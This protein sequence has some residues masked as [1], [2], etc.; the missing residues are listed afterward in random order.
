MEAQ[1]EVDDLERQPAARRSGSGSP[2]LLERTF[3]VL[4]L[5]TSERREW[6]TTQIGRECDLPVPTT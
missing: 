4:A 2:Q 3:A 5:F 1:T 6:T